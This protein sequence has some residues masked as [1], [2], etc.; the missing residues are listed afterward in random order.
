MTGAF[1]NT[2]FHVIRSYL[3]Q[4][5]GDIFER[6]LLKPAGFIPMHTLNSF[7]VHCKIVAQWALAQPISHTGSGMIK[8]AHT[9]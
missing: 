7:E 5:N 1:L 3:A 6:S 4:I 2:I 9:K 8:D